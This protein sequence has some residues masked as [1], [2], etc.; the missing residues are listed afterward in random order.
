MKLNKQKKAEAAAAEDGKEQ[1]AVVEKPKLIKVDQ[2]GDADVEASKVS[3][4]ENK[5]P[6]EKPATTVEPKA[7]GE[8]KGEE[9]DDADSE[10][11]IVEKLSTPKTKNYFANEQ[12]KS[13][14]F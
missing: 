11:A 4:E 1:N 8:V 12:V 10:S 2:D 5:A 3:S 6:V 9:A 13:E 7:E 14:Y